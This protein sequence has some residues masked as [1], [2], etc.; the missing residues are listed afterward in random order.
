MAGVRWR[1]G[2]RPGLD[3]ARG[4]AIAL[5]VAGHA[6][7]YGYA[8]GAVG[9]A[10]FFVLSGFLITSLLV[11]ERDATGSVDFRGFYERR[12][13]RLAP[14]FVVFWAV[15]L[16]SM[17]AIGEASSGLVSGLFA[18]SYVGNWVVAAGTL[19]GPFT[20]TWSLAIEEQFYLVWPVVLILALRRFS[21]RQVW[22]PLLGLALAIE[23]GRWWGWLNGAGDRVAFATELQADGLLMGS[24]LAIVMH[25]RPFRVPAMARPLGFA[26][27]VAISFV[28]PDGLYRGLGNT[29]TVLISTLLIASLV[30]RSRHDPLFENRALGFLGIISYGLYLWH[31]PVLWHLGFFDKRPYPGPAWALL[32][33]AVSLCVAIASYLWLE[34]R[35]LR[36]RSSTPE[37]Q[38]EARGAAAA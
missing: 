12:L 9:V 33:V 34:R 13:R 38:L 25:V 1:L 23:L 6:L 4:F 30:T 31:Y 15:A 37:G 29:A 28:V 24:V 3:G 10:L 19:L 26:A 7:P 21:L 11:E 5:V 16:L 8:A 36:R 18:A 17:V 27:L 32:G 35:F 20:H 2:H 14:A 22:L